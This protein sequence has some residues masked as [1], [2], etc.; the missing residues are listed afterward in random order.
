MTGE[1][2]T[3]FLKVTSSEETSYLRDIHE[4]PDLEKCVNGIL[5]QCFSPKR[6][7][8]C[9]LKGNGRISEPKL[10]SILEKLLLFLSKGKAEKEMAKSCIEQLKLLQLK[11]V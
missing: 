9:L 8:N 6:Q 7:P 11:N 3:E 1:G 2:L 10:K 5:D 4:N